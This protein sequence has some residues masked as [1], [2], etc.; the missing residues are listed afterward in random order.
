M[1]KTKKPQTTSKL[2]ALLDDERAGLGKSGRR[3]ADFLI[4]NPGDTALLTS[5]EVAQRCGV[6]ASSV[7]RL[8]QGMGFSGYRELQALFQKDLSASIA[9]ARQKIDSKNA[10]TDQPG[11]LRLHMLVDSGKSF[12]ESARCAA[13]SY[14]A[15]NSS[16][17]I[18]TDLH[19]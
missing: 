4:M 3:L 10:A 12:N 5:A 11:S 16:V 18:T 19:V 17:T 2:L 6:H 7:V 9:D 13:E 8:A 1:N 14:C 15:S